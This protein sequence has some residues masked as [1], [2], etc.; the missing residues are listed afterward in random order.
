M[1]CVEVSRK[2][3]ATIY[4]GIRGRTMVTLNERDNLYELRKII[5][6]DVSKYVFGQPMSQAQQEKN[7]IEISRL[8]LDSSIGNEANPIPMSIMY[9]IILLQRKEGFEASYD[10]VVVGVLVTD[11]NEFEWA[12][13]PLERQEVGILIWSKSIWDKSFRFNIALNISVVSP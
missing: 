6:E 5:N 11:E 1:G 12:G 9:D 13:I 4:R 7:T 8:R 3:K 2:N 10:A